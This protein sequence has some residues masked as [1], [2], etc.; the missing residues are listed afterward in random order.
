M[1]S[2]LPNYEI[3]SLAENQFQFYLIWNNNGNEIFRMTC[4]YRA[5][6]TRSNKIKGNYNRASYIQIHFD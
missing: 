3:D 6:L 2:A 4:D 1:R 5:I